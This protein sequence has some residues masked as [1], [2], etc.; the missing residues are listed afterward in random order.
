[1]VVELSIQS[2]SFQKL[3]LYLIDHPHPHDDL[4]NYLVDVWNEWDM[5]KADDS[6]KKLQY[7]IDD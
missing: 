6:G 3:V 7:R 2:S 5:F 4:Q 1:M